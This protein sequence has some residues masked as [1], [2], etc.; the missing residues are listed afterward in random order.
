MKII[1]E[2]I[3]FPGYLLLKYSL[4]GSLPSELLAGTVALWLV[5]V[6]RGHSGFAQI[7]NAPELT[8]LQD[9]WAFHSVSSPK[10]CLFLSLCCQNGSLIKK[11]CLFL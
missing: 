9:S 1:L 7:A 5:T 8:L 3:N 11:L 10:P 6:G 2:C 4:E